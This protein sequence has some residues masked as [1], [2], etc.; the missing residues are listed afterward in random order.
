[1]F[2][3]ELVFPDEWREERIEVGEGLRAGDFALKRVDEIDHLSQ[4]RSQVF[5]GLARDFSR[6]AG[7]TLSQ[8]ILEIPAATVGRDELEIVN[9][10]IAGLMRVAHFFGVNGVHPVLGADRA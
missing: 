3:G 4:N 9:V 6:D 7:E 10:K 5:G 8:E 1:M 2:V